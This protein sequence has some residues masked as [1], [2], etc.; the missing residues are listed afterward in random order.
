M[1]TWNEP[2]QE[3]YSNLF[4]LFEIVRYQYISTN[5]CERAFLV[6]NVKKMQH[7]N[8][9]NIKHLE[10]AMRLA[11][12]GLQENLDHILMEAIQL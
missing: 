3:I 2:L 8:H 9:F 11:L 12:E 4:Q 5:I 6:Q 7:K 10:S 1:I